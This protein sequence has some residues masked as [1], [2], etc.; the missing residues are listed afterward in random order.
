MLRIKLVKSLIGNNRRNRATVQ[1]LGLRRVNQVVEQ[2]DNPSIRGMI[3]HVKH[4]LHVEELANGQATTIVEPAPT[5][6]KE[7]GKKASGGR[8]ANEKKAEGDEK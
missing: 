1:A 2:P 7:K 6:T 3:H 4:M 5:E 8:K